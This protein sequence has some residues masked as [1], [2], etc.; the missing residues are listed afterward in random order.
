MAWVVAPLRSIAA[1]TKEG[2][3]VR[4]YG[5][6]SS[7]FNLHKLKFPLTAAVAALEFFNEFFGSPVGGGGG[8][9]RSSAVTYPLPKLDLIAFDGLDGGAM[10]NWGLMTY[11]ESALYVSET[12]SYSQKVDALRTVT[13]EIAHQWFGNLVTMR[14]WDEM[15]LNEG[16]ADYMEVSR[17]IYAT[18]TVHNVL[19]KLLYQCC[20]PVIRNYARIIIVTT[21]L[22]GNLMYTTHSIVPPSQ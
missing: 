10:E 6:D 1:Q 17:I 14:W 4:V 3:D 8:G 13:H 2:I 16:F 21:V 5:V 15:Y 19:R 18:Y 11:L 12:A 9:P 22:V 20:S 7:T